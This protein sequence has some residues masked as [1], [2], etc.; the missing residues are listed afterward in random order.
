MNTISAHIKSTGLIL[1]AC[2]KVSI[3]WHNLF[4]IL[5]SVGGGQEQRKK[6]KKRPKHGRL[7]FFIR[8]W[9]FSPESHKLLSIWV[10]RGSDGCGV[11][12]TAA[13]RAAV[14]RPRVR[15]SARHPRG[16]PLSGRAMRKLEWSSA[17]ATEESIECVCVWMYIIRNKEKE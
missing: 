6:I 3:T 13:R 14:R 7:I 4:N 16:G 10:R 8:T 2:Q 11:A 1:W 17:N 9:I 12:Q 15:F 5:T